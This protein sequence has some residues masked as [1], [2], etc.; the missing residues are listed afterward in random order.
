MADL[1]ITAANVRPAT[2]GASQETGIAG[3]SITAGQVVYKDATTGKYLLADADVLASSR[4]VGIALHA[5]ADNQPLT[6]QTKGDDVTI[7]A[8]VAVGE[9]YVV[10]TTTGGIA[11][12]SDLSSGDFPTILGYAPEAGKLK[13]NIIQYGVAKA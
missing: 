11:P 8:T 7:G 3:A 10:S 13:L 6:V 9:T 2:A 4:A 12:L 5:S 1:T